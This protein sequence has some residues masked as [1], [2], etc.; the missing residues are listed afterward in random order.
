MGEEF[1]DG[2]YKIKSITLGVAPR[3]YRCVGRTPKGDQCINFTASDPPY[4]EHP[5]WPYLCSDC[6]NA[7]PRKGSRNSSGIVMDPAKRTSS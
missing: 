3:T 2:P 7:E 4:P 1:I 5:N 6:A